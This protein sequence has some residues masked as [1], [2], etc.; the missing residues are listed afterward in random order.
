[1]LNQ[2]QYR[3]AAKL[4]MVD[5]DWAI[6]SDLFEAKQIKWEFTMNDYTELRIPSIAEIKNEIEEVIIYVLT[7]DVTY[8]LYD[9]FLITYDKGSETMSDSLLITITHDTITLNGIKNILET[10]MKN[11]KDNIK[12]LETKLSEFVDVENYEGAQNIQ[13]HILELRKKISNER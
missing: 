7:N 2:E 3:E 11:A 6:V 10:N 1:M 4:L 9:I 8:L 5:L 13:D 12:K